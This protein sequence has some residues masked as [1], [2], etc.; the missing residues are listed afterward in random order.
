MDV[1]LKCRLQYQSGP[2]LCVFVQRF[3]F[4]IRKLK[5][6]H[7]WQLNSKWNQTNPGHHQLWWL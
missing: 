3:E 5:A 2:G 1:V 6:R 7:L 4:L